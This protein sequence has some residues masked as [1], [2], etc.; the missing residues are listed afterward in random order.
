[1]LPILA[2]QLVFFIVFY[3]NLALPPAALDVGVAETVDQAMRQSSDH[4][5]KKIRRENGLL[6]AKED[7][8]Q[9]PGLA[10]QRTVFVESTHTSSL[11]LLKVITPASKQGQVLVSDNKWVQKEHAYVRTNSKPPMV[12]VA[13]RKTLASLRSRLKTGGNLADFTEDFEKERLKKLEQ[14][15]KT[16]KEMR[17]HAEKEKYRIG[18]EIRHR[19]EKEKAQDE[20]HDK[21]NRN[22]L[23]SIPQMERERADKLQLLWE[24]SKKSSRL[25]RKAGVEGIPITYEDDT[26]SSNSSEYF[27]KVCNFS[28]EPLV[29]CSRPHGGTEMSELQATGED[30][31]LTVRTTV[32]Y[33]DIRLPVLMETWI[34]EVDPS[35]VFVVTD[36]EDEDLM[37][38]MRSL[39]KCYFT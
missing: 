17:L 23:K 8:T 16:R 6:V 33:H 38:K 34:G 20:V 2:L 29:E 32:K 10:P 30:I 3:L 13:E 7:N 25:N 26:L 39:S 37:W 14:V 1:M 5:V 18:N 36:G 27:K 4:A 19:L 9:P 35:N 11:H 21:Q 12:D 28:V 22:F 15:K 31:L 24:E